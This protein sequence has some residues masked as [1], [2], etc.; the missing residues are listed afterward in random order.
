MEV[1]ASRPPTPTPEQFR[2]VIDKIVQSGGWGDWEDYAEK[3][4]KRK[5]RVR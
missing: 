2:S 3:V 4:L 5:R 1:N